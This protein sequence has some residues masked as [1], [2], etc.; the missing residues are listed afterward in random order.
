IPAARVTMLGIASCGV[1]FSFLLTIRLARGTAG[2]PAFSPVFFFLAS[3]PFFP[4]SMLG[5][6]DMP[7]N[8]PTAP[9][10]VLFLVKRMVWCA[11][12]STLLVLVKETS[13]TT[14]LMFAGWLWFRDQRRRQAAYFL[15]P[16]VALGAWL[17]ILHAR[18]GNWLGNAEFGEYNLGE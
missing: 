1:L 8:T 9:A 7:A 5:P 17:V 16:A 10:F 13:I 15:V 3:P 14:P 11:A 6:L 2:A 12:V 18:T 4:Q